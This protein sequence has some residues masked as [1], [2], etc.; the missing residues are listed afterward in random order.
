MICPPN[1]WS[2]SID[3]GYLLNEKNHND[4]LI[5]QS[6]DNVI[7]TLIENNNIIYNQINYMIKVPFRVN[8]KVL[9]YINKFGIEYDLY[10]HEFI[11]P[12]S[13]KF[14]ELSVIDKQN[15]L[16]DNS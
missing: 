3:G 15:A 4:D 1:D 16:I 10:N 5:H 6:T 2:P 13:D 11:D 8:K 9:D 14:K 12:E 7:H